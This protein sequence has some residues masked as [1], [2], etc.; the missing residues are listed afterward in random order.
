M[1]SK[2]LIFHILCCAAMCLLAGCRHGRALDEFAASPVRVSLPIEWTAYGRDAGG[3]RFSPAAQITRENVSRLSVAWTYRSGDRWVDDR[4]G[5][6]KGRFEATPLFVLTAP[7]FSRP[8]S[9][10]SSRSMQST[11]PSGGDSTR[12]PTST[13]TTVIL[14]IEVYRPGSTLHVETMQLAGGASSSRSSMHD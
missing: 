10:P 4:T 5:I 1:M 9:E 8:R 13:R 14:P 6:A 3:S 11:A 12:T 2:R 7:S